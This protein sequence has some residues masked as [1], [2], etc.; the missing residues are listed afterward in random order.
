MHIAAQLRLHIGA[1]VVQDRAVAVHVEL[2]VG[3]ATYARCAWGLDVDHGHAVGTVEHGRALATWSSRVGND[4]RLRTYSGGHT[5]SKN[6]RTQTGQDAK[7]DQSQSSTC[8]GGSCRTCVF[9]TARRSAAL[10]AGVF[11][12]GCR[13]FR[14]NHQLATAGVKNNAVKV[15]VH[16]GS[17]E[18]LKSRAA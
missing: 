18:K 4:L 12:L 11:A 9:S 13:A 16:A 6:H 2:T 1:A 5:R 17:L 10:T 8:A 7:I 15:L 3:I 14:Y